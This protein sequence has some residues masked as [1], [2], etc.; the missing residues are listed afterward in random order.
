MQGE[1]GNEFGALDFSESETQA[2]RELFIQNSLNNVFYQIS[3]AV[4]FYQQDEDQFQMFSA[5]FE[6]ERQEMK[7]IY[8]SDEEKYQPKRLEKDIQKA[9]LQKFRIEGELFNE[10]DG[11]SYYMTSRGCK[12]ISPFLFTKYEHKDEI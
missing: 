11:A 7:S 8:S 4:N 12:A 10:D 9:L 6:Q 5:D 2:I 1:C 3:A